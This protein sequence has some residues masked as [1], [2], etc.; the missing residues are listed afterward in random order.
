M[1]LI[2]KGISGI[3]IQSIILREIFSNFFG[4]ELSFGI[5]ISM[6]TLGGAVSSYFFRKVK[7]YQKIYI[8]FT[9]FEIL[10][11]FSILLVLRIYSNIQDFYISNLRFF[12][13]SF[14]LSFFSGFFEGV[15]FILLSFLYKDEKSSGKV[16]GFEGIGFL[17]GGF[18]FFFIISLTNIFFLLFI[19]FILNSLT[20]FY[21]KKY[22]SFISFVILLFFL[23]FSEKID[24]KTNSIKYKTF[25][26]IETIDTIYNKIILLKKENQY[27]LISNGFQE[28]SSQPDYFSIKN[29]SFFSIAFSSEVKRVGIYGSPEMI[30]ELAKYKIPEI[31]FF[32]KDRR[33]IEIIK[34][35]FL[36]RGYRNIIFLNSDIKKFL[37]EKK[38]NFDI[39]ILTNSLPLS[40]KENYFLTDEF[41]N[42][43]SNFTKNFVILLP[44]SYDYYGKILSKV[45]SSIYKTCKKYFKNEIIIFTYPMII[46]FSNE[47]LKLNKNFILDK[48]YFNSE[49]LNYVLDQNK[50]NQYLKKILSVNSYENNLSNQFCLYY[51]LSYYFSQ[52]STKIGNLM[53]SIFTKLYNVRKFIYSVFLILFLFMLF[54]FPSPY[55]SIIL[56]N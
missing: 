32:E 44:G 55:S 22:L 27:I 49:Y 5:I 46:C 23:P 35:Y 36:K 4:N 12:I 39:F 34:D 45:H 25:K 30:E 48:E 3:F 56:T 47:K 53:D 54:P 52:T 2:L 13:F 26:I 18:L 9:I 41:I 24:L 42:F 38:L 8:F 51:S 14:L 31:Y 7:E 11:L 16:Y 20:I 10:F 28:F 33:K 1:G 6:W 37:T 19:S 17:I 43:I 50:K 21:F 15:R 40:L 29:I